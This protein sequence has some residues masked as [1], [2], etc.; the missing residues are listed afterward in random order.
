MRIAETLESRSWMVGSDLISG[1]PPSG[2]SPRKLLHVMTYVKG[3]QG[4]PSMWGS[5]GWFLEAPCKS[6]SRIKDCLT[7]KV[8]ISRQAAVE[9]KELFHRIDKE[10]RDYNGA[11]EF[12]DEIVFCASFKHSP[13]ISETKSLVQSN[14]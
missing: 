10:R 9:F 11:E 14:I 5:R 13:D 6:G 12:V 3:R 2:S 7:F 1:F 8:T 4:S